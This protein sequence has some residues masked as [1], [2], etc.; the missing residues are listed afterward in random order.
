MSVSL[1]LCLSTP[2][3]INNNIILLLL[4]S[5]RCVCNIDAHLNVARSVVPLLIH[6]SNGGVSDATDC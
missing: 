2:S 5:P 3:G 4:L 1:S 6:P